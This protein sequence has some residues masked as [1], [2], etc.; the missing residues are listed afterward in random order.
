MT[1]CHVTNLGT[2]DYPT[3]YL[4]QQD[5]VN[6]ISNGQRTSALLLLEHPHVYTIGRLGNRNQVRLGS[7][8]L[9][10]MGITLYNTN[11]GGQVT[12]HGPGQLVVYPIVDLRTWG[13]PLKYVRGLEQVIIQTLADY[14]INGEIKDG[15]TGVWINDCKIAAIGVK[16]TNGVAHHG[17]SLNV[18]PHLEYYQHII[19]CGIEN[20]AST[21]VAMLL[22]CSPDIETVAYTLQYHFGKLMG[23]EMI[24]VPI[25]DLTKS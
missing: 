21:S 23:Y 2:I 20:C 14:G 19:S 22:R 24:E 10:Q 17:F 4:L 5:L 11:R 15:L 8:R 13:G 3:G 18:A 7:V 6:Q 25:E 12:Y 16:I 1:I 9:K